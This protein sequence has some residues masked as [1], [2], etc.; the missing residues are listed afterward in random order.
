[1]LT[2][3]AAV[4]VLSV[5]WAMVAKRVPDES[6]Y[7]DPIVEFATTGS[8]TARSYHPVMLFTLLGT[9]FVKVLGVFGA[10]PLLSVRLMGA[11][12]VA[13]TGYFAYAAVREA[14][15]AWPHARLAAIP[16]V[17][18]TPMFT[19]MGASANSD[20]LLDLLSAALFYGMFRMFRRGIDRHSIAVMAAAFVLGALTRERIWLL[21]PLIPTAWAFAHFAARYRDHK[22]SDSAEGPQDEPAE[23][24]PARKRSQLEMTLRDIALFAAVY[25]GWKI[26]KRVASAPIVLGIKLPAQLGAIS[27]AL[28]RFGQ[29][30]PTANVLDWLKRRGLQWLFPSYWANFG[31]LDVLGPRWVYSMFHWMVVIGVLALV[32]AAYVAYPKSQSEHKIK[33]LLTRPGSLAVALSALASLLAIYAVVQVELVLNVVA[34]GRYMFIASVPLAVVLL[35]GYFGVVPARFHRYLAAIFATSMFAV[36]WFCLVYVLLPFYY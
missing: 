17:T 11:A 9:L 27:I 30:V 7:F 12:C 8:A 25:F 24:P 23:K 22:G 20:T 1:M 28:A 10:S 18:L 6:A 13:G 4:F 21:T 26:L 35:R 19:F 5:A 15:P 29:L 33:D 34:Q 36:N 31:Y 32:L 3:L 14:M 16:L 2:L